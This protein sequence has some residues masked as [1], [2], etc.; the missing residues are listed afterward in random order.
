MR[1]A[2]VQVKEMKLMGEAIRKLEN[3]KENGILKDNSPTL[4]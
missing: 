4:S 2:D 3:K 1:A